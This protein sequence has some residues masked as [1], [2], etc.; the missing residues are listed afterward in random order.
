[1]S[2]LTSSATKGQS[3]P[4]KC[5]VRVLDTVFFSSDTPTPEW[6]FTSKSGGVLKKKDD[7]CSNEAV[8]KRF[9]DF[10]LA[11][12][13]NA[14][15]YVG[16]MYTRSGQRSFVTSEELSNCMASGQYRNSSNMG[17]FLQVYM[18]P[19]ESVERGQDR[20]KLRQL[21]Q[22][23]QHDEFMKKL[24][25][26][27]HKYHL[28]H[29]QMQDLHHSVKLEGTVRMFQA[30]TVEQQLKLLKDMTPDERRK[31]MKHAHKET[32]HSFYKWQED[33]Q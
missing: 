19:F 22:S 11:N 24:T 1:M 2:S 3:K 12:Q 6:Y 26:M 4:Q 21:Y 25:E 20:A 10:A 7:K 23:G 30:F 5:P 18:Q 27:K 32:K 17:N 31:Y 28:N 29:R 16:V 15:K 8:V 9:S 13:N 14:Q 33:N